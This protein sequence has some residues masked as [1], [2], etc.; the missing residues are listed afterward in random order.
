MCSLCSCGFQTRTR[1]KKGNILFLYYV[2]HIDLPKRKYFQGFLFLHLMWGDFWVFWFLY[3]A[4]RFPRFCV[5]NQRWWSGLAWT[6]YNRLISSIQA[7]QKSF[8]R[9]FHNYQDWPPLPRPSLW[10][11]TLFC[12]NIEVFPFWRDLRFPS[13]F[14]IFNMTIKSFRTTRKLWNHE[15]FLIVFS[16]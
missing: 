9:I 8:W 11:T 13:I 12:E 6:Q 5:K 16:C 2:L 14:T 7:S 10:Q 3:S 1:S 4:E 15:I